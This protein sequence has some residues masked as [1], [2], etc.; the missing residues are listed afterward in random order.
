VCGGL[1]EELLVAQAVD[2]HEQKVVHGGF[3]SG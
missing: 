3:L 1:A 2:L